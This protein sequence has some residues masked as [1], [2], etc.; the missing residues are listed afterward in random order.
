VD[1]ASSRQ[2]TQKVAEGADLQNNLLIKNSFVFLSECLQG[3]ANSQ[4]KFSLFKLNP[5]TNLIKDSV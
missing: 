2:L 3:V 5:L 4:I 1:L